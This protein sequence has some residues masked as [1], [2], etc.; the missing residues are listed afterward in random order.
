MFAIIL[1]PPPPLFRV[2]NPPGGSSSNIFGVNDAPPPS[3]NQGRNNSDSA[4]HSS[5]PTVGP[6]QLQTA[7]AAQKS[8]PSR[9]G[10]DS[11]HSVFGSYR[12]CHEASG[13]A[14]DSFSSPMNGG[15]S[16]TVGQPQINRAKSHHYYEDT[17]HHIFGESSLGRR[18]MFRSVLQNS[19]DSFSRIFGESSCSESAKGSNSSSCTQPGSSI[20]SELCMNPSDM[21]SLTCSHSVS[22]SPVSSVEL[23]GDTA[24]A[25]RSSSHS[26]GRQVFAAKQG[27]RLR[28]LSERGGRHTSTS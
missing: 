15:R 23:E 2:L 28:A 12:T 24:A 18:K 25:A 19:D 13:K 16:P 9:N 6:G 4:G 5:S 7:A 22:S 20:H 21:S 14:S 11:F 10:D 26:L 17:F 27:R 1:T 3:R 8:R